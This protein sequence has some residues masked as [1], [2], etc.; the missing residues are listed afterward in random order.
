[1]ADGVEYG[2]EDEASDEEAATQDSALSALEAAKARL[3]ESK[4]K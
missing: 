2:K 4:A 3:E 1:M